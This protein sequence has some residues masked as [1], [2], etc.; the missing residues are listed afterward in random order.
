[1]KY[2]ATFIKF[3]GIRQ[4]WQFGYDMLMVVK[5]IIIYFGLFK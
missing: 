3:Y 5:E 1:M 4:F 2:T